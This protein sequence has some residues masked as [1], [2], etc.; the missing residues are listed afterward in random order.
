MK[1]ENNAF[2]YPHHLQVVIDCYSGIS[3]VRTYEVHD[4]TGNM[5]AGRVVT[6]EYIYTTQGGTT[7][8]NTTFMG[9]RFDDTISAGLQRLFTFYQQF[10][11]QV[12]GLNAT[13]G[14]VPVMIREMDGRDYG[15]LGV[16]A[17]GRGTIFI[18]GNDGKIN[19]KPRRCP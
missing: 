11:V 6:Q 2:H 16:H 17:D 15:T 1:E 8:V 9:A 12:W 7:S 5:I 4:E 19:G 18:N 3:R 10:T 13:P 14:P